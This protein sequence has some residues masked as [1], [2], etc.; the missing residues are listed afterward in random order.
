MPQTGDKVICQKQ[1][2]KDKLI[3]HNSTLINTV[4]ICGVTQL[5]MEKMT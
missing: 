3:E 4:R 5:E 2:L 1:Q